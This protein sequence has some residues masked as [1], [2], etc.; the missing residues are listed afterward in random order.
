M[1]DT[2]AS[3]AKMNASCEKSWQ[4]NER[5]VHFHSNTQLIDRDQEKLLNLYVSISLCHHD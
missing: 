5:I 1:D 2:R 3:E 4:L